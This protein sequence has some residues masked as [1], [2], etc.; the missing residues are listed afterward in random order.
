MNSLGIRTLAA[1]LTLTSGC[2]D[3]IS[4][5]SLG[6]VFTAAMTG[7]TVLLGLAV[8]HAPGLA[9][10]RYVAA[11]GGFIVGAALG[12]WILRNRTASARRVDAPL[13]AV[14]ACEWAALLAFLVLATYGRNQI[15]NLD[16]YLIV[17][18]SMAMGLQGTG[19]RR[20]GIPGVTTVVIT[21]T[22]LGLVETVVWQWRSWI[23]RGNTNPE[24]RSAAR[25]S[26]QSIRTWMTVI[27]LYG[28]GA[29]VCGL[30]VRHFGLQAVCLP[31]VTVFAVVIASCRSWMRVRSRRNTRVTL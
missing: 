2:V 11:L 13:S 6:Q 27:V 8:A 12:A 16:L 7:N 25:A 29:L 30:C 18:L 1:L 4:F 22:L 26:L 20:I 23:Q 28:I 15:A 21:S 17:A 3:A 31:I 5:L 14:L 19:A 9:A 10:M 24:Q